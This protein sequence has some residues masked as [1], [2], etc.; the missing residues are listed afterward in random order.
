MVKKHGIGLASCTN[1]KL[2]NGAST[3]FWVEIWRGDVEF[4]QLYP[5]LYTLEVCKNVNVASKLSQISLDSSFRRAP[6][7]GVEQS[8]FAALLENLEGVS[9]F[10]MRDRWVWSLEGSGEFSV[11][12]VMKL[13]DDNS[14]PE[15][16]SK[17]SW[18]KHAWKVRLDCLPTRFNISHRGMAMDSIL[19]SLCEN[20]VESTRHIFLACHIAREIFSKITCWWDVRYTKVSTYEEWLDWILNIGLSDKYKKLLEGFCYMMWWHIWSFRNKIIFCLKIPSK[21]VMF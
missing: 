11:A 17:S 15:V 5:R 8:Q 21:A 9:L 1:K 16:S 13:I 14:L 6:R 7:G 18:I 2:G 19:C 10:N 12:S 3:S 20:A 4:K